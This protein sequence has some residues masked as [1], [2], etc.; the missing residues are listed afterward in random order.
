MQI[1]T[2]KKKQEIEK[3]KAKHTNLIT[4]GLQNQI[5][6]NIIFGDDPLLSLCLII[7]LDK[8]STTY[9]GISL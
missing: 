1:I 5:W 8:L 9:S 2:E 6:L 3:K 4:G 7:C